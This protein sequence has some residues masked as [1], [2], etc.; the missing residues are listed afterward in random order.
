MR[1]FPAGMS[2]SIEP[3]EVEPAALADRLGLLAIQPVNR[4]LCRTLGGH[5]KHQ[6]CVRPKK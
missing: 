6:L 3:V 2:P 4:S 5:Q 1:L